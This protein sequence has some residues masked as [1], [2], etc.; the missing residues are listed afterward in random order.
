[1]SRVTQIGRLALSFPDFMKMAEASPEKNRQYVGKYSG[2]D[3][4]L[5]WGRRMTKAALDLVLRCAS[6]HEPHN[7]FLAEVDGAD[8][9]EAGRQVQRQVLREMRERKHRAHT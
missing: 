1:M 9:S 7:K 8:L 6:K 5:R 2:A 3:D 4:W